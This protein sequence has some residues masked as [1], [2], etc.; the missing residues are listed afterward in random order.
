M[1]VKVERKNL[2]DSINTASKAVGVGKTQPIVSCLLMEVGDDGVKLTSNN[3]EMS[4]ETATIPAIP[5]MEQIAGK[6]A[7][8]A[9]MFSD[10]VRS[11]PEGE[12]EISSNDKLITLIKS[13]KSE[14]KVLGMNPEDF[15]SIK[16]ITPTGSFM[17]DCS[18]L[19]NMI[20]KTIFC[21]SQ[22]TSK[23]V[24]TGA[25]MK[26]SGGRSTDGGDSEAN[27]VATETSAGHP[28]A[29]SEGQTAGEPV[30]QSSEQTNEPIGGIVE[31]CTVD[32]F[33]VSHIQSPTDYDG[34]DFTIV[35]PGRTL[36]EIGKMLSTAK[37]SRASIYFDNR[38]VWFFFDGIKV[39]SS[40]IDGEFI[41][42]TNFFSVES[43]SRVRVDRIEFLGA[44]ERATLLGERKP[45]I[46]L[47]IGDY[48]MS[49]S[50]RTELGSMNE[51]VVIESQGQGMAISFNPRFLADFL[52]VTSTEYVD[53]N[54]SGK[55]SPC[56][57]HP[58]NDDLD[59]DTADAIANDSTNVEADSEKTKKAKSDKRSKDIAENKYLLLPLRLNGAAAATKSGPKGAEPKAT[60][61]PAD[62]PEGDTEAKAA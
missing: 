40:L 3:L 22:D 23:P 44:I 56:I 11:L 61:A 59:I 29:T 13:G 19:H 21:V 52:K 36:A 46:V 34:D 53:M 55:L 25:L 4:I 62:K 48:A 6:I 1:F 43:T 14:F 26:V 35:I 39:M 37:D 42:Y 60:P 15:P 17:I 28:I 47:D 38:K 8:D 33:R 30:E 24:L 54:F 16:E 2:L 20:R 45:P 10:I 31:M 12:I 51:E 58:V 41:N 49:I 18:A 9:R 7:I 27:E 32:G 57:I 5:S 50:A